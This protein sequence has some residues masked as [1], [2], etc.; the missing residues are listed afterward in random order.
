MGR[1]TERQRVSGV[2]TNGRQCEQ[3]VESVNRW[4]T[5]GGGR[6][7]R[8]NGREGE[9]ERERENYECQRGRAGDRGG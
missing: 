9:N 8:D 7:Q 5:E 1:L 2:R 3:V 4:V 6:G